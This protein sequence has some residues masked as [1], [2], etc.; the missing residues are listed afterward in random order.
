MLL[1]NGTVYTMDEAGVFVGDVKFDQGKIV[2]V[3]KDLSA[4]G[5]E[6][7]DCTGKNIYPGFI[8]GHSHLGMQES[9]IRFEGDD[10]NEMS[11]PLT[12][13]VRA[14]DA[15]NPMDETIHNA[16]CGGVTTVCSGPGSANVIGGT[17]AIWKT[18]GHVID[19]MVIN[20][21]AAMKCAF[22]ENPKRV[23][24]DNK[25]KTR[26]QTA[27]YLRET[28]MKTKEYMAKKALAGDDIS[29]QPA[30]DMKLEA[31]IPVLEKKIPLKTHAHRADDILTAL[32]IAREFDVLMTLDHCTEGHLIVDEV[33]A[34]GFPAFVGPSLTDKSKFELKNLTFA[35][36]GILNKAGVKIALITD[37]P[38][39]PQEYLPLCAGLAC[40]KGLAEMEALK[41]I[42][43]NPAEILG[44]AD[45]VGSLTAGKDADIVVSDGNIFNTLTNVNYTFINGEMVYQF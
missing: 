29:K 16:A 32:R 9:S 44:I 6:V 28:L 34:S 2:A 7:I 35:T 42:T 33:K 26:M 41:A 12:P 8:D 45:R 23:Y 31:M 14:I 10:V 36:A 20:P 30:Y 21:M 43:I 19:K 4:D 22:G 1:K 18:N 17:F 15:L 40:K 11:D 3:G 5:C 24:S 25:I 13:H 38:V 39:I 37:A 27:A